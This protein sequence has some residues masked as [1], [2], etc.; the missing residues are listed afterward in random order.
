MQPLT[1]LEVVQAW[2]AREADPLIQSGYKTITADGLTLRSYKMDIAVLV[3]T[4]HDGWAALVSAD[5]SPSKTTTDH[6][7]L[8][9][10]LLARK[11]IPM[12]I[13]PSLHPGEKNQ[14][15]LMNV[16]YM[17]NEAAI[18]EDLAERAHGYAERH[19]KSA[20]RLR[21]QARVYAK[22]FLTQREQAQAFQRHA[23]STTKEPT[24]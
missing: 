5:T 19:L 4:L 24:P 14:G 11:N 20:S 15:H 9:L 16:D 8:A 6:R 7:S 23:R 12:Y 10:A 22:A 1:N 2:V 13:V 17:L 21:E 18:C 3:E